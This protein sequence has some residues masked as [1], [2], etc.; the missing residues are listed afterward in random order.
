MGYTLMSEVKPERVSWLWPGRIPFGKL[1]ILDGDPGL[2]KSTLMLDIAARLSTG[3]ELPGG[4]KHPPMGTIILMVEDGLADTV[5]PRLM[6]GRADLTRI[7]SLDSVTD[8]EGNNQLPSLP[9]CITDLA[10]LAPAVEARLIIIDPIMSYLGEKTSSKDDQSVRRALTPLASFA[11]ET[12]IA[13]VVLRHFNKS[14]KLDVIYRGQGSIGFIGIARSGLVVGR[15]PDDPARSVLASSKSNL[16]PIPP[17]LSYRLTNC[18]NGA[19]RVEWEGV[20][21]HSAQTLTDQPQ[22]DGERTALDEALDF[23]RD[24]LANGPT[25][26]TA[27]QKSAREAGIAWD[28]VRRAQRRLRI[29]PQKAR[30]QDGHWTWA[31]PVD[32]VAPVQDH[33]INKNHNINIFNILSEDVDVVEDAEPVDVAKRHNFVSPAVSY[34]DVLLSGVYP[35][36]NCGQTQYMVEGTPQLCR[37]CRLG[38]GHFARS[39]AD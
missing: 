30:E 5:A 28:T 39:S 6:N 27:I 32:V 4:T 22:D 25:M 34:P 3:Q 33:N 19:A 11:E 1:T 8:E 31:L 16:G 24:I 36:A 26:T 15:D 7:I 35:C 10:N 38:L 18:D 14:S 17:S 21:S 23:L 12:G 20:S 13:V 9:S 2:G 29:S 37:R